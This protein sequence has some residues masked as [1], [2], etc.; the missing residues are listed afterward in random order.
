MKND[1]S[2]AI[3]RD[4]LPAYVDGL[5]EEETSRAVEN[6]LARCSDCRRRYEAMAAPEDGAALEAREIDYLKTVRRKG[7]RKIVLAVLTVL[8]VVLL[9][10]MAKLFIFGSPAYM[11]YGQPVLHTETNTMELKLSNPNSGQGYTRWKQTVENGVVTVTAR[12][13]LAGFGAVGEKALSIPMDGVSEVWVFG[14]LLWKDGLFIDPWAGRLLEHRVPYVG[15]APDVSDLVSILDLDMPAKLELQTAHEPYG[16]TLH[17]SAEI[18]GPRQPL[19]EAS[20]V[21]LLALV[22]NLGEVRWDW[23]GGEPQVL[24]LREADQALPGLTEAC[25][26]SL[27]TDWTARNSVKDYGSTAFDLQELM[28]IIGLGCT[29]AHTQN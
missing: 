21:L 8:L 2:C 27:G 16:L 24:T 23:P 18:K 20:A 28:E 22:D 4:L 10:A 3:V 9:G 17:F 19:M 5:T 12:E 7:H 15:S 11:I 1:L 29:A 14:Q 26:Q 25:N 13:V 6:H